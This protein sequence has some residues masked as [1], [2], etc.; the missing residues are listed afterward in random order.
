MPT[1]DDCWTNINVIPISLPSHFTQHIDRVFGASGRAWLTRLPSLLVQCREKWH[2][3][4]G[5]LCPTLRMNYIEFATTSAGESV[6]L[7]VGVLHP[8]F[9]SEMETLQLYAGR[10]ALHLL[11]ADR[12]LGAMLM[13]RLQPGTMLCQLNDN[14]KETK[15]AAAVMRNLRVA[16][17]PDHHLPVYAEWVQRAFK[18]TRTSW[19][20]QQLMPRDLLDSAE[21]AFQKIMRDMNQQ[22]VLHGDL[23]HE[24]ILF[25]AQTGWLAI[26]PKGVIGAA[27]LEVGRFLHNQLAGNLPMTER[28]AIVR[29]RVQI[30]SAELGYTSALIAACGLVDCVLSHCWHF[31]EKNGITPEWH[32]GIELAKKLNQMITSSDYST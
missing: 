12:E 30:L 9:F 21:Q 23:H 22:I 32:Q 15:I 16:P 3:N 11:D 18:L 1:S 6:V 28:V 17:P 13:Q 14:Q 19:D 25:D 29:E 24:N 20:P 10:G 8:E 5:L 4:E 27:C 7:K 26:D 2:L 31:E